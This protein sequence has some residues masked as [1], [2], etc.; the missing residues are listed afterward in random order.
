MFN[1]I[2]YV[3]K[4][5]RDRRK[6]QEQSCNGTKLS[7][8]ELELCCGHNDTVFLSLYTNV[9]SRSWRNPLFSC[10]GFTKSEEA[11]FFHAMPLTFPSFSIQLS[12]I[13]RT[14]IIEPRS[15]RQTLHPHIHPC[16]PAAPLHLANDNAVPLNLLTPSAP[17]Q[18]NP[19]TGLIR[20]EQTA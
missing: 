19:L 17:L 7:R 1:N 15:C 8:A 6:E 18:G 16:C 5:S 2:V 12:Q 13:V 10:S 9:H 4:Q 14:Y 20:W 11:A 3:F